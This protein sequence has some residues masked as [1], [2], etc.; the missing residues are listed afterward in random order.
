MLSGRATGHLGRALRALLIASGLWLMASAA[1]AQLR[2]V[3]VGDSSFRGGPSMRDPQDAFPARLEY[4]LRQKGYNVTVSNEGVNGELSWQTQR[5]LDSAVPSGTQIA[6]VATG[7]NDIV[8]GFASRT[9]AIANLKDTATTLHARGVAVL[10]FRIGSEVMPPDQFA[11]ETRALQV[12]GVVLLPP[13]QAGGLVSRNELHVEGYR[14]PGTT[15]WHLNREG[16]DIVVQRILPEIEKII[17]R[18]PRP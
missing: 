1:Q 9:A 4:A 14:Q 18:L 16:N 7:G 15:L 10:V 5:R 11:A 8:R 17:A 13:M 3:A 6:L 12:P 2:I